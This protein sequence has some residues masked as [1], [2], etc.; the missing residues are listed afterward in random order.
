MIDYENYQLT[1][2]VK[3]VESF[4]KLQATH[5]VSSSA[6]TNIKR[7]DR[8]FKTF[9]FC[10]IDSCIN[11]FE[12][13]EDLDIHIVLNQH[14]TKENSLRSN[15]K[16]KLMLFEKTKDIQT[17]SANFRSIITT[18][19]TT[20]ISRHYQLFQKSGWALRIRKP[21]KRIDEDVKAY[22]KLVFQEEK[23]YGRR[24]QSISLL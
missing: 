8:M 13:E 20:S 3:L 2:N 18:T 7:N 4:E 5:D 6:T 11:T 21:Y 23:V 16:A 22:L 12:C 17:S 1:T 15:D 9:L 10:P 14:T 24:C 19:A